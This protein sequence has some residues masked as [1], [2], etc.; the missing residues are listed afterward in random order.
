M[1]RDEEKYYDFSFHEMGV[2]DMPALVK[3]VRKEAS[4][5]KISVV[6]HG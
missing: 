2:Y 4:S 6:A 5:N 3:L 1:Q